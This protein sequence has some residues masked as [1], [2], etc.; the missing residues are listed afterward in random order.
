LE[1]VA[2]RIRKKDGSSFIK[3]L[4]NDEQSPINV[5][6]DKRWLEHNGRKYKFGFNF[7]EEF[8]EEL[9]RVKVEELRKERST[10]T[11][12]ISREEL[13]QI[14]REILKEIK[15]EGKQKE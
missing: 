12:P 11:I 15:E 13:K 8:F 2:V 9:R 1:V 6:R 7:S 3:V 14:V 10:S 5:I 4:V